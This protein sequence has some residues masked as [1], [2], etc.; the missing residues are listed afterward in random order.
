MKREE[1]NVPLLCGELD[2]SLCLLT[3]FVNRAAESDEVLLR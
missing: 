1:K 3:E 2:F